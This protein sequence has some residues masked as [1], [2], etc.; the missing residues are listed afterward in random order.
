M[1][2]MSKRSLAD[3]KDRK[4]PKELSDHSLPPDFSEL[5][6]ISL[7]SSVRNQSSLL[8]SANAVSSSHTS[9]LLLTSGAPYTNV[10]KKHAFL[11]GDFGIDEVVI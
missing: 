10:L 7:K 5:S 4:G 3:R 11:V 6:V 8:V 2:L 9:Y 1:C